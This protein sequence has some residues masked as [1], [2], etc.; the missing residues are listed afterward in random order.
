MAQGINE[1]RVVFLRGR[2][3]ILRPLNKLTDLPKLLVWINDPEVNRYLLSF[4]PQTVEDEEK[5]FDSLVEKKN[6]DI[7]LAIETRSGK[8][9]G[10][11]GLHRISWKDGVATTGALIGEKRYRGKGYGTDAK[12]A[13]LNYAF[14]T[15]NLRKV[16]SS[17]VGFNGRSLAYNFHCGYRREGRRRKQFFKNGRYWD[18]ILL[19]CFKRQWLPIWERYRRT[20]R[21]R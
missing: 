5:W 21:V 2:K 15:L 12:M 13:L 20:G 7:V 17:V 19:A 10:T 6:T 18:E 16:C 4:L 9:I 8:F 3:T 14:N 11:M 1:G